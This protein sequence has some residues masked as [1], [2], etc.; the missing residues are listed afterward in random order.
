MIQLPRP[1]S[2]PRPR[3]LRSSASTVRR[4][5]LFLLAAALWLLVA[6][7]PTDTSS[8]DAAAPSGPDP[9]TVLGLPEG[10]VEAA[11]TIS[12]ARLEETIRV[13]S[14]DA[15]QG[16]AP[17]TEGD[18]V[19]QAEIISRFE[20]IGL[21][22]AGSDGSWKQPFEIVGITS[23]VPETWRFSAAG[24]DVELDFWTEF[25]AASGVQ[26]ETASID[27]AEI[28]FVGYG[29]E[30]P[31]YSWDDFGDTDLTG[32]VLLMLNNDPAGNPELFE[33]DRRLYYGRWTYK[34]EIAAAKGAAG[35]III[36]TNASA[37]YGWNV[38]Q[39]GWTGE[40]VELPAQDEPRLEVA[41]W[42]TWPAA[43]E[44]FDL[45]GLNMADIVAE[46]Q[47]HDFSPVPMGI[48]TSLTLDN[49]LSRGL[50]TANILG[51][52]P[53]SDP[54]LTDEAVIYTAHFDHLGVGQPDDSGDAIFN[55]A[56]DNASGVAQVLEIAR[57]MKALPEAPR[58]SILFALVAAEEQGLL[59]S[60]YYAV[61]PTVP[62]G[63][64]A[65]NINLDSANIFGRT[66]DLVYIGY[67]KSSL[68]EV[69]EAAAAL[70]D[71]K[72]VGDQFPDR[73]SFY[74][75]DQFSL[76]KI[77]V[78]AVYL[79]GGKTLRDAEDPAEGEARIVAWEEDHYHRPSDELAEDWKFDGMAEDAQVAFYCGLAVAEA[80]EMPT[81]NPG[82]EFEAAR[83]EALASTLP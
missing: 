5:R 37:G 74:R 41:G 30:A 73:G 69:V 28:V 21:E 78:P 42:V 76:A 40:Q 77:G 31:E 4:L 19:A 18:L 7:A 39:S 27:G 22:P 3:T 62:P 34:Y 75:S 12:E 16:R 64:L 67:G 48:R 79:R 32:K 71:R 13:L 44:L 8:D 52:L 51:R 46:A 38:V 43:K 61:E 20:E 25:I 81:W 50:E 14:D 17:G 1:S 72:V 66:Q 45:V 56:R 24:K 6:C 49:T 26:E 23:E 60:K 68:D 80:D 11:E 2:S 82:D 9:E 63:K 58:R 36:H 57:A 70:Q 15:M 59:G 54:G 65:A 29:I 35:A 83:Q 53:G 55:G 47:G 33:G 10:A